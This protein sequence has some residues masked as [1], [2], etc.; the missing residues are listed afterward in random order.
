MDR[1]VVK[2]ILQF[3]ERDLFLRGVRAFAGFRQTGVDYVRPERMFGRSTNN[4]LKNI[5]WAKKGILSF[6]NTPLNF[7]SF[8]GTVLLG[9]S[10]VLGLL[11]ALGKLLFPELVP[12]GITTTLL[13]VLFFGSLNFLGISVLGEY[14]AKIFEEVKQRP[15]FIRRSIIRDGE[16]RPA[17]EDSP[18]AVSQV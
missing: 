16:V 6:S 9:L 1:R 14:L 5:D 10:A 12:P 18:A 8:A 15:H 4:L 3:P 7:M 11:Q 13:L 17:T 2:A